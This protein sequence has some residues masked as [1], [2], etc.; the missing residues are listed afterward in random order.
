MHLPLLVTPLGWIVLGTAG[1]LVYKAGKN[2]GKKEGEKKA[3][4][5]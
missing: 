4:K 1:Y 2:S 5:A 3:E